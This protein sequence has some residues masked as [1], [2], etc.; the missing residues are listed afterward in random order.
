MLG[1]CW[2]ESLQPQKLKKIT[3]FL[4][5]GKSFACHCTFPIF[6][7][8]LLLRLSDQAQIWLPQ[9]MINDFSYPQRLRSS[10]RSLQSGIDEQ[11]KHHTTAPLLCST[12]ALSREL[13][14]QSKSDQIANHFLTN[15]PIMIRIWLQIT[16]LWSWSGFQIVFLINIIV[17]NCNKIGL[18]WFLKR[19]SNLLYLMIELQKIRKNTRKFNMKH[20]TFK[21][22]KHF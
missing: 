12:R 16:F 17:K 11:Q 6:E 1:C 3:I 20:I 7:L 14:E 8:V 9:A 22:R 13:D 10:F 19:N 4:G 5:N 15:F 2:G 18:F 21:N